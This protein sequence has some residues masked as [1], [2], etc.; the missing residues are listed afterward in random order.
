MIDATMGRRLHYIHYIQPVLYLLLKTTKI[1]A[2][3]SKL[4]VKQTQW[5]VMREIDCV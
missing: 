2:R 3:Y 1:V 5:L 4:K